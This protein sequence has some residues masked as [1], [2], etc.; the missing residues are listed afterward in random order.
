MAVPF[1]A[2]LLVFATVRLL[3]A[4]KNVNKQYGFVYYQDFV[5]KD[6]EYELS[7][8]LMNAWDW[9]VDDQVEQKLVQDA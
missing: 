2:S 3:I 7:K 1:A 4:L 5:I 9:D 8:L 6:D